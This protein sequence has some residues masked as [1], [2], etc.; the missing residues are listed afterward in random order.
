MRFRLYRELMICYNYRE[1][2]VIRMGKTT[3]NL[4]PEI[5][6]VLERYRTQ[7]LAFGMCEPKS[8]NFSTG[9]WNF[10]KQT[11]E[12]AAFVVNLQGKD[13]FVEVI[14]GFASTAFT[15]MV[16]DEM[17]LINYGI[18]D[19]AIAVRQKVIIRSEADEKFAQDRIGKMYEQYYSAEKDEILAVKKAAQ[20]AFIAT[21][22]K[23]LKPL[24]FKKKNNSWTKFLDDEYYVEFYAQKSSFSDEYYFNIYIRKNN[25][26]G[27]CYYTRVAPEEMY[28][29][30]WQCIPDA[31]WQAFLDDM[32]ENV[33]MPII[34]TPLPELGKMPYIW[35]TC[36]CD[37]KKCSNCWV[38]KNVWEIKEVD[39]CA[40]T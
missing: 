9:Y 5:R 8:C 21:I 12:W 37:R 2:K 23:K 33:L 24:G 39:N 7:L 11:T 3:E 6:D 34:D 15:K 31:Q 40:E 27:S 16:G 10:Y 1:R 25:Q 30:D 36:F 13:D 4:K 18:W 28:P 22:A 29:M 38:E 32:I 20:K 26:N 17:S 14:F 35:E 19:E